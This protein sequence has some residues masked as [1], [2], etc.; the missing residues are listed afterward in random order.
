M[1]P[2]FW[3]KCRLAFRCA[4]FTAWFSVLA[5][6]VAFLWCNRIGLPDFLK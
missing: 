1:P 6:L 5:V 4:R 2:G 3:R